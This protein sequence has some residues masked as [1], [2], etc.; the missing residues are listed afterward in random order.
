MTDVLLGIAILLL[1]GA[2]ALLLAL[3]KRQTRG[4]SPVEGELR[5]RIGELEAEGGALRGR[6]EAEHGAR[7]QAETRLESERKNL[8]DQRALLDEAQAKL[9]DAFK[10]LSAEAL[11]ESRQEFL[12]TAEQ[13]LRPIQELLAEYQKRLG[14]VEKT[15]EGAYSG[16]REYLDA[17]RTAQEGL[18]MQTGRLENALR[19]SPGARGRWG[20][21]TLRRLVELAGMSAYCDFAEQE[22]TSGEQGAIRPDLTVR[23]PNDRIVVVDSKVP[24]AAYL[25]A[26]EASD[27]SAR[28]AALANHAQQVR[29]H[30]T[31]L[32]GKAYWS[33]L[34]GTPDFVVCFIPGESFFA[35]AIEQD[36]TLL[37]R[38]F[39]SGVVLASPATLFALLKAVEMGW[40]EHQLAENAARIAEA[41]RELHARLCKFAEHLAKIGKGLTQAS[42]AY[43]DMV[44]SYDRMLLPSARRLAELGA[45]SGK[46]LPEV[47]T[48]EGPARSLPEGG[49]AEE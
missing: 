42:Q 20:E 1:L 43:D 31:A 39:R 21:L 13:R 48:V 47:P 30:M 28:N 26:C 45:S 19:G 6:V 7:L 2:L 16:L 35:A 11:K 44:G 17:L 34:D 29:A 37:E 49:T 33:Q 24:L 10:A 22:T 36:R 27:E 40:R 4:G 32:M 15:R 12:S 23:L 5:G 38:G 46:D 41:G 14:E 18:V 9:K 25:E 8:A 3:W